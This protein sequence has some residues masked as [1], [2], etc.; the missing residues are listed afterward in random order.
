MI[1]WISYMQQNTPGNTSFQL[2]FH[3]SL[4]EARLEFESFC[5]GVGTDECSAT[6]Y[7]CGRPGLRE[8]MIVEAKDFA[9][10]GC[11][12]DYPDRLMTVGPRG[13][14]KIERT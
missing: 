11:P 6:L 8:N 2:G 7:W 13:G 14:V 4:F 12:F 9:D 3:S 5:R 1:R 10:I